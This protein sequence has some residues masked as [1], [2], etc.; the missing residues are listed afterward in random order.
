M[1][2]FMCMGASSSEAMC[3][4]A[5]ISWESWL[6]KRPENLTTAE[7]KTLLLISLNCCGSIPHVQ[8][9]DFSKTPGLTCGGS[10]KTLAFSLVPHTAADGEWDW[11][12]N[13]TS[14]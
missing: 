1:G 10:T 8:P 3:F 12:P 7:V 4:K 14:S 5:M 9:E 13:M 6:F 2:I 11:M